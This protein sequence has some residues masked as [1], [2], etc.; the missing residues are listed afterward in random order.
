MLI[1]GIKPDNLTLAVIGICPLLIIIT[2]TFNAVVVGII[3]FVV[4][5]LSGTLSL[6]IRR[7]IPDKMQLPTTLLLTTTVVALMDLC[8]GAYFY[9]WHLAFGLYVPLLSLNGA[10]LINTEENTLANGMK[11]VA[12]RTLILGLS[13]MGLLFLV[14]L[15]RD[16][17]SGLVF[18]DN[19][20]ALFATPSG[21][22]LA[23]GLVVALVNYITMR[24]S[25]LG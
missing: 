10:M 22:F 23:L 8:L 17:M 9:Q 12:E 19:G 5:V 7:F 21:A 20:F 11:E 1:T 2:S 13:I 15:L 24:I 6:A 18:N 3:F 14:G 4:L 25:D 16:I